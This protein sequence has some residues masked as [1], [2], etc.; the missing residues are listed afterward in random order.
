MLGTANLT[1]TETPQKITE[2]G[3]AYFA[4]T[5]PDGKVCGDCKFKGYWRR[6]VNARGEFVRS[7]HSGGCAKFH[8]LTGVHGPAINKYLPACKYFEPAQ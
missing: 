5:G 4:N 8:S 1:H 7:I 2:P 6:I 3:M